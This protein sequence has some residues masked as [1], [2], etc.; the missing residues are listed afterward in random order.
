MKSVFVNA[1]EGTCGYHVV[2]MGWKLNVPNCVN[3][4]SSQKLRIW[5]LIVQHIHKWLYSWMTPGNVEGEEEYE[6]SKY[7]LEKFICLQIMMDVVGEHRLLVYKVIKFLRSNAYTWETLYL[8]YI[9]KDVMHFDESHSSAHEGFYHGLKSHGCA[10]K[11]IMNLDLSANTINIQS[12]IKVQE[13][14]DIIFQE[15]T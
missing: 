14:E 15:A 9:Q 13:C 12:S 6:L 3:V 5:S 4:I 11:P 8:H 2:H 7:L 10:V 1:S